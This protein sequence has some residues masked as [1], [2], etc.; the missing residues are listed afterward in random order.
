MMRWKRGGED[1]R[2]RARRGENKGRG[3]ERKK[4]RK[5]ERNKREEG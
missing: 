4:E 5:K 3:K 2:G 1:R